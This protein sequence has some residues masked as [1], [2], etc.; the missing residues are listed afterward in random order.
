MGDFDCCTG[1]GECN[2]SVVV[3]DIETLSADRLTHDIIQRPLAFM[4]PA[5]D[6]PYEYR[7]AVASGAPSTGLEACIADLTRHLLEQDTEMRATLPEPPEGFF[8]HSEMH[9]DS[10]PETNYA[11]EVRVQVVYQL[12]PLP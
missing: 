11:N 6:E 12:R 1:R 4:P 7:P 10:S 9:L 3:P 8:W 5:P 2:A